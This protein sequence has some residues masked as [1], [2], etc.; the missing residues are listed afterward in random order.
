MVLGGATGIV[1]GAPNGGPAAMAAF[2]VL[3]AFAALIATCAY[4]ILQAP[5]AAAYSALAGEA[6]RAAA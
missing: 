3:Q 5:P 6:A 1:V 4:V 2:L